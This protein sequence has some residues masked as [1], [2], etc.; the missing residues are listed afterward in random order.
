[1]QQLKCTRSVSLHVFESSTLLEDTAALADPESTFLLEE[2]K[3][4][5][6]Y[7]YFDCFT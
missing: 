6:Y 5:S 4:L 1:M 2:S 3:N 7:N